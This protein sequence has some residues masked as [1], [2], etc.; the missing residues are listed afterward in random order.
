MGSLAQSG[1]FR[2]QLAALTDIRANFSADRADEPETAAT[3]RT[4]V[5]EAG[6]WSI[7]IPRSRLRSRRK[8]RAILRCR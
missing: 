5:R 1:R 7:R 2:F 3:I 8:M 6:C 4:F